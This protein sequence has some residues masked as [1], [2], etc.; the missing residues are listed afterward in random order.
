[1]SSKDLFAVYYYIK[2]V[3]CINYIVCSMV[4]TLY[5]NYFYDV[6]DIV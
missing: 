2:G 3:L 6:F 5:D 1:M 4:S